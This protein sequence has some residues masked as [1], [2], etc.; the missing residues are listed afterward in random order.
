MHQNDDLHN[1]VQPY[2]AFSFEFLNS[3]SDLI[4]NVTPAG[5]ILF[6][7][8]QFLKLFGYTKHELP[9]TLF[10]CLLSP[11]NKISDWWK[12]KSIL[13]DKT[14]TL[15]LR[16]IS[17]NKTE[18][19]L[20]TKLLEFAPSETDR[21][22]HIF[23]KPTQQQN[24]PCQDILKFKEIFDNAYDAIFLIG[25]DQK[26]KECNH[27]CL[28]LFACERNQFIGRSS[29][30]FSPALQPDKTKSKQKADN[31]V[32]EALKGKPQYFEWLHHRADGS[33]FLAEICVNKIELTGID[34]F[35]CIAR[36]I[37]HRRKE[38]IE[39]HNQ[40]LKY[41]ALFENANDGIVT[42]QN[43]LFIDCNPK[44][45]ELF[46]AR[47]EQLIGKS[48]LDYSPEFQ[49][50]GKK[51]KDIVADK[52][53][54]ALNGIPQT[55]EWLHHRLDGT[56]FLAE[57]CINR[58]EFSGEILLQ[59]IFK[60][61]TE[62]KKAAQA[63]KESKLK[64]QALFENANDAI[65]TME[66]DKF[67]DCNQ[68]ALDIFRCTKEEFIGKTPMDFSPAKQANNRKSA[69]W[70]EEMIQNVLEGN[71]ISFE[72]L[73][74]RKDDSQFF[75]EVSLN[76]FKFGG[77]ESL[78]AIVRDITDKK[79]AES[80]LQENKLKY[81]S[82]FENA[83]D[84]IFTMKETVFIDCNSKTFEMFGCTREQI[85]GQTPDKFS[86]QLQ[87]DKRASKEL[88]QEKISAALNGHPQV[89][90]WL[91]CKLDGNIFYAE[92]SLNN[93]IVGG[94]TYLQATVRDI[95]E[96]KMA[97]KEI[98]ENKLRYHVM[99]EK[100]SDGIVITNPKGIFSDCNA[101]VLELFNCHKDD[102]LGKS[103]IDFSPTHQTDGRTSSEAALDKMR[104]A[105]NGDPQIFEWIHCKKDGTPFNAEVSINLLQLP[106]G[107]YLYGV[108]RDITE[109][110]LAEQIGKEN[111]LR[112]QTLFESANDAIFTMKDAE[113]ID[114]NP[115]TLE[116]FDCSKEQILGQTP[117]RFSPE[118]QPNKRPSNE[119][120]MENIQAALK[121]KPQFFEWMH[122]KYDGTP[123]N[124]EISLAKVQ[125][126]E[127][128]FLQAIV[129]DITER[130]MAESALR[131]S[132]NSAMQTMQKAIE[133]KQEAE[134]ANRA[135]S[136]FLANMSHEIRTPMNAI[137]GFSEVL[138][139]KIENPSLQQ[140][141]KAIYSSGKS[142]LALIN[143]I[144][145]LSKIEAGKLEIKLEPVNLS[146]LL[147]EV[148]QI[149][150]HKIREK[151]LNFEISISEKLPQYL[152][153]DE[154]R[155]RQVLFN[156]IGNAVK[157]TLKGFVRISISGE[158][159][160]S[161]GNI[162]LLLR[163]EDSGIGIPKDQQTVIFEAF[164]QQSGQNSRKYGG[165][166][167]G[168]TITKKLVEQMEGQLQLE[169]QLGKG[170]CFTIVFP[171]VEICKSEI[172]CQLSDSDMDIQLAPCTIMVVDDMEINIQ[173][174]KSFLADNPIN[175]LEASSGEIALELLKHHSPDVI[176]MDIRMDGMS[177]F[178]TNEILK[179]NP[180]T[181]NI[182]VI[183]FTASVMVEEEEKIIRSFEGFVPKPTNKKKILTELSKFV[184]HHNTTPATPFEIDTD[185]SKKIIKSENQVQLPKLI[186]KLENEIFPIWED[187]KDELVLFK[188][189]EFT[190]NLSLLASQYHSPIL[191]TYSS[192]LLILIHNFDI[193]QI[194]IQLQQFPQTI[195]RLHNSKTE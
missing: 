115:K 53:Q 30:D 149:F 116:I 153:L 126:G 169:S 68:R 87:P 193:T 146:N 133:A 111:K 170:S 191:E 85:I 184:A 136:E 165:T 33:E 162:K 62:K 44:S 96:R 26:I 176:I 22:F 109:K 178:Q 177:G 77:N 10:T 56:E 188:I 180:K 158:E 6:A 145:D 81:Q 99:F 132:R 163:I 114:C 144:L 13:L 175:I 187:I 130:K 52:I 67:V 38:E 78:Q 100:A 161:N 157:F 91:H 93:F 164:K 166:G 156:L 4:L 174:I 101:K 16:F 65:I 135:K 171:Q 20:Q 45:M 112:Y 129:R 71:S 92:V 39:S 19:H 108:V 183:A 110:K 69:E 103:P 128:V 124:A 82:L 104:A 98:M 47:R 154:V 141:A 190:K 74:Q 2:N 143:D 159:L 28:E 142:L 17:H 189:E 75:V 134:A 25:I 12:I 46:G 181:Q 58:L 57:V 192:N 76:Q 49:T 73:H 167:L 117:S 80:L 51:S 125:L 138:G 41:Q 55:F 29:L 42:L 120:S 27:R 66:K 179:Q 94:I 102:F 182:P 173:I 63:L 79:Q 106:D 122:C 150:I 84:A 194:E 14:K 123:F 185:T 48:P 152:L 86:P 18:L 121:G 3:C 88:A 83:N 54:N 95:S 89:F 7:N 23:L 50:C 160:P 90:E 127:D 137:L 105:L 64:Y 148:H 1:P 11:K 172:P 139:E 31:I 155:I 5:N 97:E 131:E 43:G 15:D 151:N 119:M 70:A 34:N 8:N 61:I 40:E 140:Q 113:F 147:E 107:D 72:W 195:Q 60:D 36:D 186:Q 32:Q 59:G 24:L 21:G 35:L 37:T 168:L 9:G 118:F